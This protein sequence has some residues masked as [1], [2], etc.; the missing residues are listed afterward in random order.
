M[1]INAFMGDEAILQEIGLRIAQYRIEQGLTQAYLAEEAGISKRTVER[2]EAGQSTQTSTLV[3][4]F[5]ILGLLGNIGVLIP[6]KGPRPLDLLKLKGRER[7]R[8]SSKKRKNQTDKT[9]SW[10]D[11]T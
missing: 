2:I 10:G 4:I 8:A 5:R 7:Q 9:W 11:D 1:D 3:R 6:E